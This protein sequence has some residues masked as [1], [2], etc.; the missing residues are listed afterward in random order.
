MTRPSVCA[1]VFGPCYHMSVL[2]TLRYMRR[3]TDPIEPGH[4]GIESPVFAF[5]FTLLADVRLPAGNDPMCLRR[6]RRAPW[7][8]KWP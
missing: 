1:A 2:D 7:L 5:P 8:C 4:M 3:E 6:T